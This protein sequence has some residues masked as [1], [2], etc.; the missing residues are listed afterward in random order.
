MGLPSPLLC[1]YLLVGMLGCVKNTCQETLCPLLPQKTNYR[2][3]DD[4]FFSAGGSNRMCTETVLCGVG[5]V[6]G[7]LWDV[8]ICKTL[9]YRDCIPRRH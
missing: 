4:R 3:K 9:N 6:G 5:G 7:K 8:K 1:Q 2:K